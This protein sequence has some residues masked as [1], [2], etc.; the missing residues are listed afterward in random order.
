MTIGRGIK[1]VITG[2]IGIG[3]DLV[4]I[5]KSRMIRGRR[6]MKKGIPRKCYNKSLIVDGKGVQCRIDL[7]ASYFRI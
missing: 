5:L 7:L 1:P 2:G 3:G 4:R 6:G